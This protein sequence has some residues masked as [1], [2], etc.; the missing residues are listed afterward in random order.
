MTNNVA[1]VEKVFLAL[2]TNTF[3]VDD[4]HITLKYFRHVDF[5]TLIHIASELS[6][7]VPTEVRINGFAN[8]KTDAMHYE[9]AMVDHFTN[10]HL[11]KHTRFP[12]ITL[13]KSS[14]PISNATFV[15]EVYGESAEII[16]KISVGKKVKGKIVW[17]PVDSRPMNKLKLHWIRLTGESFK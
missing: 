14:G 4:E 5:I 15:P 17:M 11:F 2:R 12:H 8:Y 13:R 10:P 3:N 16:D 9:V 6:P 7:Y 1:R